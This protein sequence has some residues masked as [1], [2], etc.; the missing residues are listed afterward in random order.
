M[1]AESTAFFIMSNKFITRNSVTQNIDIIDEPVE[2]GSL[3]ANTIGSIVEAQEKLDAYTEERRKTY[4]AAPEGSMVLPPLWYV[5][6]NVSIEMELSASVARIK[7]DIDGDNEMTDAPHIMCKTLNSKEV[8]L[9]G[10][11][12]SAGLRVRVELAPEGYLPIKQTSRASSA[13]NN[14][15]EDES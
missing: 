14:D 10:R 9:F 2:M 11:E 13:N 6:Q 8:S 1:R 12:A 15:S 3:L 7:A 5:F 4:E